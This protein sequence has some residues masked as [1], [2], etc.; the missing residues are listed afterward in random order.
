MWLHQPGLLN[1]FLE[2]SIPMS[3]SPAPYTEL[4][5]YKGSELL[6]WSHYI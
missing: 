3:P 5:F 2:Q 1:D 6:E 4:D